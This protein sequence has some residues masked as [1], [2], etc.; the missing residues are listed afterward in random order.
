MAALA[1]ALALWLHR[2]W[3]ACRGH[4]QGRRP[5]VLA[6]K[7]LLSLTG[8]AAAATFFLQCLPIVRLTRVPSPPPLLLPA[9]AAMGLPAIGLL[10]LLLR[11]LLIFLSKADPEEAPDVE[12][13][14]PRVPG[15][16]PLL[17]RHLKR[18]F[19]ERSG[20]RHLLGL[21]SL[22]SAAFSLFLF[23]ALPCAVLLGDGF[24]L[25]IT[26]LFITVAALAAILRHVALPAAVD[27]D[28]LVAVFLVLLS[29]LSFFSLGH[30]PTLAN[31]PW[32]TA[33]VAFRGNQASFWLPA[34]LISL[35]FFASHH[36]TGAQG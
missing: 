22:F 5:A 18:Q 35:N 9:R 15:V 33:F 27:R 4:L 14:G 21:P 11:P 34:A 1:L 23:L 16:V 19:S 6:A 12:L 24:L 32:R 30:Q 17:W 2:S 8:A 31:I 28:L 7:G 26:G 10:L 3:L 20:Q 25:S 29:Q 13:T 36:L